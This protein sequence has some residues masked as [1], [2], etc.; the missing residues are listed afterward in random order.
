MSNSIQQY[1]QL[2]L[3]QRKNENTFRSLKIAEGMIDFCSNDYLGFSRDAELQ[4]QILEETKGV[5]AGIGS[6]GSR[7]LSGNSAYAENLEENLAEFHEAESALLMN[8]GFDANYGLLASLP[9]KGDTIIYDE[10]VH[11]SIHDGIRNS[12]A[13]SLV[14]TH[15][16][17]AAL[18]EK[19]NAAKGLKYVVVESVYSMDGDFAPLREMAELCEKYDAGLIVDEAHATGI[20][21]KH[22]SGCVQAL[23]LQQQC[24]ARIHTFGKAI[25]AHGAVLLGSGQLKSFLINYCRPFIFSTA[26]PLH[27]LIAIQCAYRLLPQADDRRKKLFQ[28]AALFEQ[29]Y[30]S[31]K[32][33]E[34]LAGKGAIKSIIVPGTEQVKLRAEKIQQQGFD[35][36]PIVYPT[37]AKGAERIRICIHSFNTEQEVIKLAELMNTF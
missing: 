10:L 3:N 22:G 26:L 19:L 13:G 29:H 27:T 18:E 11:A 31:K 34:L 33:V 14:F 25:G 32:G 23:N 36:R 35:I 17:L 9:Y 16:N 30:K 8:S 20:F 2:K 1:I 28:L 4:K 12:K 37:V 21:G 7:L 6:T 24:L 5:Q 15:N